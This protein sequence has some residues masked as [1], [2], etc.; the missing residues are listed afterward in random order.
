MKL[1]GTLIHWNQNKGFGFIK[2]LDKNL[3]VFIHRS[4]FDEYAKLPKKHQILTFTLIKD[5]QGR[6]CAQNAQTIN[7]PL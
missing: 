5:K 3:R 7:K 2:T 6:P 4:A 1:E